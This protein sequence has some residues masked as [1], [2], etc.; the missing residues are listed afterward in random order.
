LTAKINKGKILASV[1]LNILVTI[2]I[3]SVLLL[4]NTEAVSKI[5]TKVLPKSDY[6]TRL[7][8]EKSINT[9]RIF[10]IQ[11]A[12]PP[13]GTASDS[14]QPKV[15]SFNPS[16]GAIGV[17]LLPSIVVTFSEPVQISSISTSTFQVRDSAGNIVP[18][19]MSMEPAGVPPK[20]ITFKPTSPLASSRSY[21]VTITTGV[22]DLA[23]NPLASVAKSS[24]TTGAQAPAGT[25]PPPTG[26]A[27][28]PLKVVSI[29][30]AN[31]ATGVPVSS[32]IIITFNK[33]VQLSSV[34]TTFDLITAGPG[35]GIGPFQIPSI[36]HVP[37]TTTLSADGKILTFRPA[38]PLTVTKNYSY[39]LSG[40][41]DLAGNP[42]TPNPNIA[43]SFTTGS[44]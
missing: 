10:T 41:K 37:G 38:A 33:A 44:S 7:N 36:V 19:S 8:L 18:G 14:I 34:A 11:G 22:K 13:A 27:T 15:V 35:A 9:P 17:P 40:P 21:S 42:L 20:V 16:N 6:V 30:P 29:R 39:T 5:D 26:T 3:F 25:S 12:I 32:S 2:M 23:G 43:G 1:S 24:F 28:D 4:P 31:G